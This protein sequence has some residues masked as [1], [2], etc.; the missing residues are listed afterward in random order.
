VIVLLVACTGLTVATTLLDVVATVFW[1]QAYD[2]KAELDAPSVVLGLGM[3]GLLALYVPTL[4]ATIVMWCVW[5]VRANHN[6]RALGAKELTYSPGWSAGW[7][8]IPIMNLFKPYRALTEIYKASDPD[9]GPSNWTS[10]EAPAYLSA[11][12]ATWLAGSIVGRISSRMAMSDDLETLKMSTWVGV[13][14]TLML[15]FAAAYAIR[16]VRS[17]QQRQQQKASCSRPVGVD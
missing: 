12:W 7:Y 3:L 10:V 17:I 8:F 11:W 15:L 4:V 16:I 5:V 2:P 14:S 13:V 6:N 1:P 9:A